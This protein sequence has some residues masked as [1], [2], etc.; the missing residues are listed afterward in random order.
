[1]GLFSW[2]TGNSSAAEKAVDG[3]VSGVDALFYTDEEKANAMQK[4]FALKIDFA[5]H[6]AFMSISRRVIV[7]MVTA[8]WGI[9]VILLVAFGLMFGK[10]SSSFN[11]LFEV[12]KDIVNPPFMIIVAFYFMSQLASKAR[13]KP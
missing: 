4:A 11:L 9:M 2:L 6:T 3:V 12:M 1:M 13:G 5:K 10:D 8:L 7:C